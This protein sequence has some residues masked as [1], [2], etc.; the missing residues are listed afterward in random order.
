MVSKTAAACMSDEPKKPRRKWL[1]RALAALIVLSSYF[2]VH[3]ATARYDWAV[4]WDELEHPIWRVHRQHWFGNRPLP[5]W[6]E[7]FFQ[8]ASQ[9]DDLIDYSPDHHGCILGRSELR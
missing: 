6:G 9:F 8:P 2:A 3:R 1:S 7:S 4:E 5:R